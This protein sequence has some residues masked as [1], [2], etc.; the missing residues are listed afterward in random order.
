MNELRISGKVLEAY[1]NDYGHL[2]VTLA[3][4]HDHVV[5]GYNNTT[6]SILRCFLA[7]KERSKSIEV[8]KGDRVEITGY[9]RQDRRLSPSG[10]ERKR[11]NIYIKDIKKL[12]RYK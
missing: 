8:E 4:V 1:I 7:D 3:V 5:D 2:T 12:E 10:Q 11:V 9:L 6:E